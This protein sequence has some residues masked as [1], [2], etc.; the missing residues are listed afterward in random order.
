MESGRY[1]QD[2]GDEEHTVSKQDYL[3]QR[4]RG[5]TVLVADGSR[6]EIPD[7]ERNRRIYGESGNKY[8]KAK[9]HIKELKRPMVERREMILCD[10]NK[11]SSE[12]MDYLEK[13][14]FYYLIRLH[15]GNY[16]AEAAGMGKRNRPI[17]RH[18]LYMTFLR[19]RRR[20][21][22]VPSSTASL[23][24]VFFALTSSLQGKMHESA[25]LFDFMREAQQT[26]SA[27]N[28]PLTPPGL[29]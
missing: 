13:A 18:E 28:A 17:P 4:R 27:L 12:L 14:G 2:V 19:L 23:C 20:K 15:S 11:A 1:F 7:G 8:G 16:K 6:V 5:M 25:F 24:E 9:E 3:G 22:R 10:R 26:A 29:P 21:P